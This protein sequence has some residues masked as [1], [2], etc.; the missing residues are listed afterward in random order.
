MRSALPRTEARVRRRRARECEWAAQRRVERVRAPWGV[1]G[2]RPMFTQAT[3]LVLA[4]EVRVAIKRS[5]L[6]SVQS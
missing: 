4:P 5:A 2:G 3:K 6:N 1:L